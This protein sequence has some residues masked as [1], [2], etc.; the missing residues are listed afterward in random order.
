L[1]FAYNDSEIRDLLQ[2]ENEAIMKYG[3]A[4]ASILKLRVANLYAAGGFSDI[5]SGRLQ[6][7]IGENLEE[8]AIDLADDLKLIMRCNHVKNTPRTG[9][10]A[11]DW[12]N[13]TYIKFMK[14]SK[15]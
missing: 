12:R 9:D 11:I 8:C 14:I 7:N 5:L 1:R 15:L 4:V 6:Y 2:D 13:V 10:G 3:E